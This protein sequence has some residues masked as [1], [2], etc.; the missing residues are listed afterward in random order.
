MTTRYSTTAVLLL[1]L[2][3]ATAPRLALAQ[4]PV[5]E[6]FDPETGDYVFVA[7]G[8]KNIFPAP[9]AP[10]EFASFEKFYDW[11]SDRLHGSR[12]PEGA[13]TQT[14]V[15]GVAVFQTSKG[16]REVT[17][18]TAAL[19]FGEYGYITVGGK[20]M[21]GVVQS[22]FPKEEGDYIP[23]VFMQS[24]WRR[25]CG[26][27]P[28]GPQ[29][30]ASFQSSNGDILFA[31]FGGG[32]IAAEGNPSP[33]SIELAISFRRE[34]G[35]SE[36]I[37]GPGTWEDYDPRAP[38]VSFRRAPQGARSLNWNRWN[39][40]PARQPLDRGHYTCASGNVDRAAFSSLAVSRFSWWPP[41]AAPFCP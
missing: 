5:L 3:V 12:F 10:R 7:T 34:T 27:S 31:Q 2:G 15:E 21:E 35:A 33:A 1:S 8:E 6:S 9:S 18:A 20:R 39:W 23:I 16:L 38:R 19:I 14:R 37:P 25:G 13:T 4:Q 29:R 24:G 32:A 17:D 40:G 36:P 22:G 26:S 28:L 41:R 11:V 30:C